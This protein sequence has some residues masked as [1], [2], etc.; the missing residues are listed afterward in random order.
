MLSDVEVARR[1]GLNERRYGH[2]VT[3]AREPNLETLVKISIVLGT[4]PNDLLGFQTEEAI[5]A[6][7]S[8]ATEERKILMERI[9]AA[10]LGLHNDN[11]RLT[12]K[13][14]EM[15]LLHQREAQSSC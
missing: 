5:G 12:V 2:Y 13:Q 8:E 10:C 3:G 14:I 11:L 15:L 9:N 7:K 1:A 4:S 6:A